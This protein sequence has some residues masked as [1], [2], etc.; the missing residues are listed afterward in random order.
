MI[1]CSATT[2]TCLPPFRLD[3]FYKDG[4]DCMLDGYKMSLE[5]TE[6]IG[7]EE[8]NKHKIYIKF[9]CNED[10]SNKTPASYIIIK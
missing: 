10:H 6:E 8:I 2:G 5:K 4:Y 7:R 9:G 1:I 3:N